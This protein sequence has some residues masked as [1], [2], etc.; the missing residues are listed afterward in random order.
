[1]HKRSRLAISTS[2]GPW[3]SNL[4]LARGQHD[5]GTPE[6]VLSRRRGDWW[7]NPRASTGPRH[8]PTRLKR[9]NPGSCQPV[10][11]ATNP[12]DQP[13][14]ILEYIIILYIYTHWYIL[15]IWWCRQITRRVRDVTYKTG[16]R[17][18]MLPDCG[19]SCRFADQFWFDYN[20]MFC[21]KIYIFTLIFTHFL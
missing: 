20:Y 21:N 6:P 13:D 17:S 8:S 9:V 18:A 11:E 3:D 16:S 12:R 7:A 5:R 14:A 15:H 1:M 19:L 2:H 4:R 10:G